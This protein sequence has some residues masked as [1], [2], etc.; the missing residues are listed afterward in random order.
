M[1]AIGISLPFSHAK[2]SLTE[3]P[4]QMLRDA[5]RRAAI[6]FLLGS[7]RTSVNLNQPTLIV[8]WLI[9]CWMYKR[10]IFLKA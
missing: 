10:K 8:E 4:G 7:L 2:R 1:L 6:L 3:T 9:L 5:L